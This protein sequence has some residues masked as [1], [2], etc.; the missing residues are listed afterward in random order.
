VWTVEFSEK[1]R[2]MAF[3]LARSGRHFDCLSIEAELAD[4]GY[5][6]AYIVLQEAALRKKLDELCAEHRVASG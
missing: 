3:E 4:T 2:N 6:E 1:V 5:P